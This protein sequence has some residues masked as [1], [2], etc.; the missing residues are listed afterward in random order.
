MNQHTLAQQPAQL[1]VYISLIRGINVG[2]HRRVTMDQLQAVYARLG[3]AHIVSY[4]QTGNIVFCTKL[5]DVQQL[6][7]DICAEIASQLAMQV[8]VLV[9]E[10]GIWQQLLADCPYVEQ[11]HSSIYLTFCEPSLAPEVLAQIP[12]DAGLEATAAER[13]IYLHYYGVSY[14]KSRYNNAYF[15]KKGQVIATTRNWNT[16]VT[17]AHL[18]I[19]IQSQMNQSR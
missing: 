14:G 13:V 8:E 12:S 6:A 7:A 5:T 19:Q 10:A 17:L 15:E 1:G 18:A 4:I 16:V 2:G 3:Y 11:D 9:F